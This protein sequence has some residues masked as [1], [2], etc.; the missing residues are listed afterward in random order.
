MINC[1]NNWE[2]YSLHSGGA[3][4]LF[5]DGSVKFLKETISP[6]TFAAIMTRAC[7]EITSSDAY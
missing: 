3:N 7:G 6:A 5:G 4:A 2:A 1:T